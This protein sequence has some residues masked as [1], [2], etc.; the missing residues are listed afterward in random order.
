MKIPENL[1]QEQ[2]DALTNLLKSFEK[3]EEKLIS[4]WFVGDDSEIYETKNVENTKE[5]KNLWAT[6]EQAEAC[7]A[8]SELS[9]LMKEANGKWEANWKKNEYKYIIY[10]EDDQIVDDCVVYENTF[11]SFKIEEVRDEFLKENEKLIL[12]AKPLL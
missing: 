6:K 7:L 10:F 11:L 8:M 2:I 12:K 5:F 4:G 3:P 1:N 9:Q